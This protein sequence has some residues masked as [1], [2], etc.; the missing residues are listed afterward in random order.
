MSKL[1]KE[2]ERMKYN[3]FKEIN[4]YEAFEKKFWI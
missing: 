4:K 1:E 2:I 3:A